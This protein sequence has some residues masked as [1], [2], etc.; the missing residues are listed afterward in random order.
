[1][2]ILSTRPLSLT[3]IHRR[4]AGILAAVL[5]FGCLLFW[6]LHQFYDSSSSNN[7]VRLVSSPS[8]WW[9]STTS[10]SDEEVH[11]TIDP[12]ELVFTLGDDGLEYPPNIDG[13]LLNRWPR[14]R[15]AFV[16]STLIM[17]EIKILNRRDK[18]SLV[19]NEELGSMVESMRDVE[20][21][22]NRKANVSTKSLVAHT[23]T[24]L[25]P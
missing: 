18:V 16:S 2:G 10:S 5:V 1:M 21:V 22:F 4:Q 11:R 20:A 3:Q 9:G 6:T 24:H 14:A 23:K 8:S 19:R 13:A 15:A 12:S 7:V 17:I 25:N